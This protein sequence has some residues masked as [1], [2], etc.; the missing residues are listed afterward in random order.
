M[1][2]IIG[3]DCDGKPLYAG[4]KVIFNPYL[5]PMW[6]TPFDFKHAAEVFTVA[7]RGDCFWDDMLERVV[8]RESA[9]NIA[10]KALRKI[11]DDKSTW[12]ETE[13]AT[14]WKPVREVA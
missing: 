7:G 4:D 10:T 13:K 2:E 11:R 8:V 1:N 14:G 5:A 3:H 9:F 6:A 12:G